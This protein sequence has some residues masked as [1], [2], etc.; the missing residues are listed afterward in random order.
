[1]KLTVLSLP[2]CLLCL[3]TSQAT[4][5]QLPKQVSSDSIDRIS[6]LLQSEFAQDNPSTSN[7]LL[8]MPAPGRSDSLNF[9]L[10][11]AQ[12]LLAI[13]SQKLPPIRLEATYNQSL[14]LKEALQ[15][16][17]SL[18]L[19]IKISADLYRSKRAL[20]L[21]TTGRLLPDLSMTYRAQNTYQYGERLL[22]NKTGNT[23]LTWAYFQGGRVVSGIFE[24]YYNAKAAKA[25]YKASINDVLLETYRNY[26][27]V[28]LNQAILK[29]RVKSLETSRANLDFTKKQFDAGTGTKFAVMQSETQLASD[30]QNLVTQQIATRRAAIALSVTLNAPIDT[31]LLPEETLM[32]KLFIIDP[33]LNANDWTKI[34]VVNRPELK[35]L[36]AQRLAA[37][38][39]I[40]KAASALMPVAQIYVSPSNSKINIAGGSTSTGNSSAGVNISTSGTGA[41][42]IGVGGVAGRSVSLGTSLS[43]NLLGLGVPDIANV[44]SNRMLARRVMNQYNQRVLLV[45]Q[46]VHNF[47]LELQG[48]EQQIDITTENV[49]ASREALRLA[50]RRLQLGNGTNLELIQAQQNYVE[51]LT[52][53]IRAYIDHRNAQAQILR[54]TGSISIDTL[55][56]HYGPPSK[57]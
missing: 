56:A 43:W 10:P 39:A 44:E 42:S 33:K 53:Q 31:N 36:E 29:V 41:S 20:F 37:R 47:F 12:S 50:S 23:T 14:T 40:P 38:A 32:G 21:G 7:N 15:Q 25:D 11:D 45:A 57:P 46:E 4:L 26:N 22:T 51:A 8:K 9:S 30:L 3:T 1:M 19:P 2:I 54:N 48:A 35:S 16:A 55:L 18:N 17:L 24:G 49:I 13:G 6:P 34:A 27:E 52:K 28:L 5:A